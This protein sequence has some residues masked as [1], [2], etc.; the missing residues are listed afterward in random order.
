[1][2]WGSMTATEFWTLHYDWNLVVAP[3]ATVP[4][5]GTIALLGIAGPVLC[6][7]NRKHRVALSRRG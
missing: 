3:V 1:M 6:S 2:L 4:E 5:P 7:F